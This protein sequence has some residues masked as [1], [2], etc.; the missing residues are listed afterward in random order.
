MLFSEHGASPVPG[1][2]LMGATW[3][4]NTWLKR[5]HLRED[6][7]TGNHLNRSPVEDDEFFPDGQW[8]WIRCLQTELSCR[9]NCLQQGIRPKTHHIRTGPSGL[10]FHPADLL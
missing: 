1:P 5:S 8:E 3:I 7:G 4:E 2:R 10:G 6:N 9:Q